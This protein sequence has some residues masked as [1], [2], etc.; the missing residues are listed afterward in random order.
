[1]AL[2]V[3]PAFLEFIRNAVS[4][5]VVNAI[6]TVD[7][8]SDIRPITQTKHLTSAQKTVVQLYVYLDALDA[9]G[10]ITEAKLV[11]A[12]GTAMITSDA[13]ITSHETG[14]LLLFEIPFEVGVV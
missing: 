3:E 4:A 7:G 6:I 1:M 9:A 8:K 14:V 2:K 13:N 10:T 12:S 5:K 11:D